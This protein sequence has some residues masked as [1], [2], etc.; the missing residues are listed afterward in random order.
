MI[1]T[2]RLQIF[3]LTHAELLIYLQGENLM[4]S[5]FNLAITDRTVSPVVREMVDD[6]TLTRMNM[7]RGDD[8]L[9]YTFW[10]AVDQSCNTIVAEMGFKG[11]PDHKGEIEIGYGTMPGHERKGYMTDAVAGMIEWANCRDD[12]VAVLAEIDENNTASICVVQKNGFTEYR[13]HGEMLW[14]RKI[15]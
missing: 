11:I 3:P 8:Y 12:V 5:A 4:E 9:F 2:S 7:A 13:K 15:L 10:V 14:W 6:F 1:E